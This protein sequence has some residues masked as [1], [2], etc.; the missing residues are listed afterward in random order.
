MRHARSYRAHGTLAVG[1]QLNFSHQ[2]NH[3]IDPKTLELHDSQVIS[4][5]VKPTMRQVVIEILAYL[6][7]TTKN[8]VALKLLFDDV[9]HFTQCMSFEHMERNFWAG[10]INYWV[11][12]TDGGYTYIYLVNGLLAIEHKKLVVM[13]DG[14]SSTIQS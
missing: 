10:N 4:V 14:S 6:S 9:N 13:S 7:E 2:A 8:R 11:P 1:R 5:E 3:V 12:S